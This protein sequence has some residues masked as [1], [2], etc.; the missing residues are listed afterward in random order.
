MDIPTR[1]KSILPCVHQLIDEF[2]HPPRQNTC[3]YLVICVEECYG[4]VVERIGSV[5]TF[6][7]A[8]YIC[9]EKTNW[10]VACRHTCVE[11][12]G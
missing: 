6:S 8:E 2:P 9:F 4:T 1:Y 11:K 12:S 5:T 7:N 3:E 10:C